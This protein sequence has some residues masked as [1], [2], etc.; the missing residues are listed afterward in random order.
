[1]TWQTVKLG[2]LARVR[3]GKLDANAADENGLYP[4]FTC[5]VKPLS[6]NTPAFDCKAILVAG[7]GDLNVKYYEGK[8]NAYQRT[9]VIESLDEKKLLPRYLY[10]FLNEY[11]SE[12]RALAIGGVIKYIK[13]ANL[14]DA[15]IPLPPLVEQQ[16]IAAIL[17]QTELIKSR[18]ELAIEKLEITAQS[19]FLQ[20]FGDPRLNEKGYEKVSIGQLASDSKGGASLAPED[21]I[22]DGFPILHKGAIKKNG[23]ISIDARKKTFSS[24]EYANSN[25]THIASKEHVVV[26]LRDLVPSGPSIG[27]AADLQNGEYEEYLLAQGVYAFILDNIKVLPSYFVC[28]SNMPSF[29]NLLRQYAVGSTQIH[30]RTP[31]YFGINIPLPPIEEQQLFNKRIIRIS[32][33]S[34]KLA[35][36]ALKFSKFQKSLQSKAFSGQL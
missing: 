2:E 21:F 8:F 10:L 11:I 16:R 29:R 28:L 26:T 9:Y 32:S 31:V 3:T 17:D 36:S 20:M 27:L 24:F 1:M 15:P 5:A 30:I 18:R 34:Q 33:I 23:V 13:L 12:L 19:L 7:N 4:F 14:T 25:K 35:S 6:I 22:E